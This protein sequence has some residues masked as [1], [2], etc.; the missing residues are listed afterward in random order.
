MV[1]DPLDRPILS[2]LHGRLIFLEEDVDVARAVREMHSQKAEIVMVTKDGKPVGIVTDSDVLDKVVI[3]GEDSDQILLKSIASSPVV[4]LSA[5]GTVRQALELMRINVIK[6]IPITDNIHILGLV[7]QEE[8]ANAIRT[9][10]LERAFRNYRSIIRY[11]YEPILGNLGFVMQF[12]GILLLAPAFLATMLNET[13]TATGIFL[14][15][16]SM[17]SAG[18]VLNAYGEKVPLNLKQ[19]SILIVSSFV[20]LS[21]FGSIPYMYVNPFGEKI[22]PLS[23]FVDSFFES[24][25]GFTTTGLSMITQPEEL[26]QSFGLYRSYTQW[27]GG[28]S[29]VYLVVMLFYPERK[30]VHMRGMIG[31]GLLR[32]KQLIITIS[33]IFTIYT[34]SLTLLLY[35]LGHIN[36]LNSIAIVFSTVT[37]GGFVPTSTYVS[38]ENGLEML[39]LI[40][41]MIISALPFAF[42]YAVF[43]KEVKTT[44]LRSEVLMYFGIIL[45]SIVAFHLLLSEQVVR[46]NWLTSAFHTISASTNSGFQYINMSSIPFESRILLIVIML[47]GGCAFSTAGG[48]KVGRLLHFVQRLTKRKVPIDASSRSISSVSSRYNR[49]YSNYEGRAVKHRE[50]K[51]FRESSLVICLF[52]AV[53]IITGIVLSYFAERSFMDSLFESVSALT[54]TG[55]STGI[56]TLSLDLVSKTFLIINMV[57][58]RFEIIAI[59]Y[60]FF[61]AIRR[62]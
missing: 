50:D 3:K 54:T 25:S 33:V 51:T 30:L 12:A 37:G 40:A 23:L 48:I 32:S 15:L 7:T 59:L 31:G 24:A 60:I 29:F 45:V 46:S 9:S 28:L 19:A 61:G 2:H 22:D 14:G 35:S 41:G 53:S 8:L 17:S 10:V 43:S 20:L 58:G 34:A 39:V 16:T 44:Q 52:V 56:T 42:H 5:N 21:F 57:V 18:F 36:D 11:H 47:I 13:E 4:T 26:P 55:L 38:A 49:S 62:L 1:A 27:V 6:H